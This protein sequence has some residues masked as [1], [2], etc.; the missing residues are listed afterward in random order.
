MAETPL[1][2]AFMS[3]ALAEAERASAE[4]EVPV[5]AVVV[6]EG[7]VIGRGRNRR[8]ALKDPT[9]HAEILALR[10]A[11]QAQGGWRLPGATLYSTLE[12]CPMCA[13]ALI[14]ARAERLV[15]A[16]RDPKSGSAGSLYDIP[17]DTR[18]NHRLRVDSGVLAGEAQTLLD[19]F[20][21]GLRQASPA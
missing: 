1:D 5:G 7:Q 11:S 9:A 17:R 20:F 19:G 13:G 3:Q 18:F 4:G 8:E 2:E 15:Y 14:Q 21:S 10:Q 12:P 6:V 16:V